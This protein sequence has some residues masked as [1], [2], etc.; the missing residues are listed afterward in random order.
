MTIRSRPVTIPEANTLLSQLRYVP[1]ALA[2]VWAAAR[3]W[4]I[5]WTGLLVLQ[6]WLPVATVY[7]TRSVVDSLMSAVGAA[8]GWRTLQPTLFLV[9]VT[10][11]VLLLIEGLRGLAEWVRATQAELVQDHI[12]ALIHEKATTLD[13]SFYDTPGYYDRLHRARVD[14]LN[15]PVQLMENVGAL[16]QHGLTLA[17]MS[18]V[19]LTYTLWLPVVL[20]GSTLP[21]L[22]VVTWYG[23]R[24]HRWRLRNTINERRTR[25]YDWLLTWRD[26][27]MELR[28]FALGQHYHQLFQQ[29]RC[30]NSMRPYWVNGS[31]ERN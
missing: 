22:W 1:Q 12:H 16:L 19:L 29:L 5:A 2:L 15:R 4:T 13:I 25:Y 9:G 7:L 10:V 6:A 3:P 28:L 18:A 20:L 17:A 8:S 14:A 30:P 21:A 11:T 31:V 23:M 27:A 26:A 24:F